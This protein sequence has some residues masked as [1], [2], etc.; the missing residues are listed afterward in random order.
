MLFYECDSL[1]SVRCLSRHGLDVRIAELRYGVKKL[2]A[3]PHT[4]VYI[5]AAAADALT[6]KTVARLLNRV[7]INAIQ[8]FF[9]N[10]TH[11]DW[12]STEVAYGKKVSSLVHGK[13]FVVSTAVNGRGPLRPHSRVRCG[14]E[15]LCNRPVAASG[16]APPPRPRAPSP[17]AFCGSATRVSRAVSGEMRRTA[18][19]F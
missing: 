17:T 6:V 11:F 1:V 16:H 9:L 10:S 4:V 15:V 14:N 8:G 18:A 7:D 2:S 5:G 19:S 3:L 13:H 12:T